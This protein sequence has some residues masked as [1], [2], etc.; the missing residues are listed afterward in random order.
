MHHHAAEPSLHLGQSRWRLVSRRRRHLEVARPTRKH[1]LRRPV[2]GSPLRHNRT[3]R[4]KAARHKART[5]LLRGNKASTAAALRH[6]DLADVLGASKPAQRRLSAVQRMARAA[7]ARHRPVA[8]ARSKVTK[9]RLR[10]GRRQE[11][12]RKQAIHDVWAIALHSGCAPNV[13]L[14]ELHELPTALQARQARAHHAR[15]GQR[16]EHKANALTGR[17]P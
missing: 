15:R 9:R 5:Q 2:L 4:T 8:D 10:A 17:V 14:P 6:H 7:Q 1:Q 12:H 11:V 13:A 3:K 16:V